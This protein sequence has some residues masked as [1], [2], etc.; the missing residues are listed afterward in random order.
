[1]KKTTLV[2]LICMLLLSSATAMAAGKVT[3]TSEAFYVRP[4]FDYYAGE[5]YAEIT[6][7][8]DKPVV[9]NGGMIELYNPDGDAIESSNIYSCYPSILGPGESGYLYNTTSVDEAEEK[10]YIDDYMLTITGKA[11]NDTETIRMQS[12]GSYG[13]F[14]R[15]K[16]ST[17]FTVFALITNDTDELLRGIRVVFAL[18]DEEGNLLY[19]DSVEP[20]Y[21]GLPAGETIEVRQSVDSR[22][23]EAWDAEGVA[24]A[25]IDTIA[26][27]EKE[28]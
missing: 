7:T 1:M 13:E 15:S 17:E 11:E 14:Q 22:I 20:Y 23:I 25:R 18:F 27:I 9:Y 26:Y 3:V 5:I 21:V 16:Y 28:L 4:Y 24:P 10:G 8:G 2:L 19:A 6:N 12:E